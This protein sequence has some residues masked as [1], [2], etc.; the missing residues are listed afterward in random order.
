[1]RKSEQQKLY[2]I[3]KQIV[4]LSVSVDSV[5]Y[6]KL[7]DKGRAAFWKE[8]LEQ[9]EDEVFSML[10]EEWEKIWENDSLPLISNKNLDK[11]DKV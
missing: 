8:K 10:P 1:M 7:D 5:E 3:F 6:G 9:L 11:E 2:Q 4:F